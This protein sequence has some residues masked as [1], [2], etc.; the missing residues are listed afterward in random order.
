MKFCNKAR[1]SWTLA[2]VTAAFALPSLASAQFTYAGADTI[3][4]FRVGLRS[5]TTITPFFDDHHESF[6]TASPHVSAT[7]S[8]TGVNDQSTTMTYS[9][10]GLADIQTI[11]AAGGAGGLFSLDASSTLVSGGSGT[12]SPAASSFT[13]CQVIFN[14]A[15]GGTY[16]LT[17]GGTITELTNS[18]FFNYRGNFHDSTNGDD[19]NFSV[20][21]N[22]TGLTPFSTQVTITAGHQY[23][24]YWE[25]T[26]TSFVPGANGPGSSRATMNGFVQLGVV[27]EPMSLAVLGMGGLFMARRRRRKNA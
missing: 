21:N 22:A 23:S 24:L 16:N 17:A 3:A 15:A 4:D 19:L 7:G 5:G 20:A 8:Y 13:S 27:P 18:G 12:Y 11:F 6:S 25:A 10:T 26:A 2:V 1:L 9:G 14:A